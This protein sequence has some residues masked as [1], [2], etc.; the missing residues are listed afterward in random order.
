MQHT[1]LKLLLPE[2]KLSR[3]APA[4]FNSND[5]SLFVNDMNKTLPEVFLMEYNNINV[6]PES[7]VWKGIEIAQELLIYP[8]HTSMYNW[9]Y[10][11][12]NRVKRRLENLPP[13][14]YLLCTDYWAA[15]Y[16]HWICDALPRIFL[17]KEEL[18]S[19]TLLMP[20]QYQFSYYSETL[21]AFDIGAIKRIPL[22]N[23]FTFIL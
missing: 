21:E 12:S 11:I 19:G 23:I 13:G 5:L 18:V 2:T 3:R 17:A 14:K 10:T 22:K 15:G 8:N 1:K 6:T 16:F 7:I 20:E 9:K 4:N